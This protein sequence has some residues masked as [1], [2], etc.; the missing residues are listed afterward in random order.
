MKLLHEAAASDIVLLSGVEVFFRRA[1]HFRLS[2]G[3]LGRFRRSHFRLLDGFGGDD[4]LGRAEHL[5]HILLS[6][7]LLSHFRHRYFA[8]R[9]LGDV[10]QLG[11]VDD[12]L[13]QRGDL[14]FLDV[15]QPT[16]FTQRVFLLQ[17][18]SLRP[19]CQPC[20]Y[21]ISQE[22][23]NVLKTLSLLVAYR[24]SEMIVKTHFFCLPS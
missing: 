24:K 23:P 7:I 14:L 10:D 22:D 8:A 4:G 9:G 20:T 17:N 6:H 5:A 12:F 13:L 19:A 16:L 1:G 15:E 11:Q 21:V 2:S 3:W 18:H